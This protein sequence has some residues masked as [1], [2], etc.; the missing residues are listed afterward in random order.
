MLVEANTSDYALAGIISSMTPNGEIHPI[1]FHSHTFTDTKCNYN[2]HNKELLVIFKSFK[3]W[4]YYLEGSQHQINIV[5]DHKNLEYFSTTKMLMQQQAH[6]SEYLSAF[7]LTICFRP[8][9]LK[10]KPNA[11]THHPNMYPKGGEKDIHLSTLRTTNQSLPKNNS[12]HHYTLQIRTNSQP[13]TSSH[14]F[15]SAPQGHP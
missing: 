1:A 6:W 11:L 12:P 5:T 10:A 8:S 14:Q 13:S 2:T 4:C 9:K 3:V 7:N 15:Q